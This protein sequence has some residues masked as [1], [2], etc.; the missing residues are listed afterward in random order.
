MT[1][2]EFV[3]SYQTFSECFLDG[4]IKNS[5]PLSGKSVSL[6]QTYLE[7]KY[8]LSLAYYL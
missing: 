3:A 8:N 1:E 5:A 7:M 4:V 6:L 2:Q